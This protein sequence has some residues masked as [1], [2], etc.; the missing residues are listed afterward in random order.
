MWVLV[1]LGVWVLLGV[2]VVWGFSRWFR[3]VRGQST[4][5][6]PWEPSAMFPEVE[7]RWKDGRVESRSRWS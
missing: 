6:T 1:V 3:W 5:E 4:G 2:L 7:V